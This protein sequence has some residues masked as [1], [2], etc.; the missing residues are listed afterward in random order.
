MIGTIVK[1]EIASNLLS[2]KFFIVIVLTTLLLATSFFVLAKD[3]KGRKADYELVRA[4]PGEAI[5]VLA[6]NPLSIF[7]KGL[8]EAMTRSFEISAIGIGVRAGQKSGNAIFAFFPAP[9]FVYIVKV[10]LSLVAL[11]FGFDQISRERENGVLRLVLSNSVSRAKVL[12][13]KW[14]GNYLS[15]AVPFAL[16]TLIGFALMNLD[17]QISFGAAGTVRFLVLLAVA[18]LYIALFLSLGL[19]I[20]ALTKKAASSLVV[21]LLIWAV[22]VFVLP[23]IGTLL[24]RQMVDVPSVKALSEKRQQIWTREILLAIV[25][26]R[27][28]GGQGGGAARK[29]H[30]GTINTEFDKLESDYRVKFDRLVRLSKNINR[31]SPAASFVYAATELAGTG[32]AEEGLLKEGVVRYKDAVLQNLNQG[33]K[34]QPAFSYKYR[35]VGQVMVQGGLFDIAW[36]AVFT[37]LLFA[38]GYMAFVRYD[39]R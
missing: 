12:A 20:S 7:A 25:E 26:G 31:I 5:A 14:L 19:L 39:V 22:A 29:E 4:K 30:L 34:E 6:P 33:K 15:L 1:K 21:L 3:F 2:Y 28:R 37:I 17:P 11:L 13:G 8:D 38:G 23:N 16:V 18:L 10:V 36:L 35:S 32:I 27:S 9:D 24:A